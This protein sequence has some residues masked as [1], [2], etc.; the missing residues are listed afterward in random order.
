MVRFWIY[1]ILLIFLETRS[2]Y[3]AQV[4]LELLSDPPAFASQSA[5]ITAVNHTSQIPDLL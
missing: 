4:G 3:V 2:L 1:F 5:V